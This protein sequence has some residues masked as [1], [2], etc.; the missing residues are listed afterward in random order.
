MGFILGIGRETSTV[1]ID[2]EGISS[3][4]LVLVEEEPATMEEDPVPREE[5][6]VVS[7]AEAEREAGQEDPVTPHPVGAKTRPMIRS[8]LKNG[9]NQ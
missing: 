6:T 8:A 2:M 1:W 5:P 4:R 9:F 3:E 7:R